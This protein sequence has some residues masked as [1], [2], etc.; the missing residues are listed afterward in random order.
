MADQKKSNKQ[1][2]NRKSSQNSRYINER[3]HEKSH[4]KRLAQHL[5]RFPWH[6]Q[7]LAAYERY[8]VAAGIVPKKLHRQRASEEA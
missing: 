2:R 4:I 8:C 3:R 6:K 1:D 7:A 5:A